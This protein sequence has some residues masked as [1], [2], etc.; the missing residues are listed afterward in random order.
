[1]MRGA[2]LMRSNLI[3]ISLEA[4]Y[5]WMLLNLAVVVYVATHFFMQRIWNA[6]R[7]RTM[8]SCKLAP[9]VVISPR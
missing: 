8:Q 9:V 1:M 7:R 2:P 3:Q 4:G 5:A 6:W